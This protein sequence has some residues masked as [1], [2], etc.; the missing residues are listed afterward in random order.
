M[1]LIVPSL[2]IDCQKLTLTGLWLQNLEWL[3]KEGLSFARHLM[4]DNA[5]IA[6]LRAN[7]FDLVL[8]DIISWPTHLLSQILEVPEVDVLSGVVLLP[9]FGPRYSIPNPL[10]Y[11]PQLT[12]GLPGKMVRC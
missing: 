9:F 10:G 11:I 12:T 7:K 1:T 4:A 6:T 8:R 3:R 5:T 2:D